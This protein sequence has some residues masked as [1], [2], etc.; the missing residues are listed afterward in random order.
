MR[1]DQILWA[2]FVLSAYARSPSFAVQCD[3]SALSFLLC[4]P[5]TFLKSGTENERAAVSVQIP[6][7]IIGLVGQLLPDV[8]RAA[9]SQ[10]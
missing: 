1:L 2:A 4:N 6:F 10:K 7:E 5:N 3:S 8:I 9:L